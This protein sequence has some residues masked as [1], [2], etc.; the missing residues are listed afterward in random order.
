[1]KVSDLKQDPGNAN[2]GSE[3]GQAMIEESFARLGSGRSIVVDRNDTILCGNH[4][5]KGAEAAGIEDCIVVETTGDKLVVVKRVDLEA[6]S[7]QATLLALADNRTTEASLTWDQEALAQAFEELDAEWLWR[8]DEVSLD[9]PLDEDDVTGTS[10]DQ[11][12]ERDSDGAFLLAFRS[13]LGRQMA[14]D[15]LTQEGIHFTVK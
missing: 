8:A 4:A 11:P 14:I 10:D 5:A 15:L 7:E 2:R 3:R 6:G 13:S 9:V 1:M 12:E